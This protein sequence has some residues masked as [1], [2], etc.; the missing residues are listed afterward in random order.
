[1]VLRAYTMHSHVHQGYPTS[2]PC[3]I[4]VNE[5]FGS[6]IEI[7]TQNKETNKEVYNVS[8]PSPALHQNNVVYSQN[9]DL[10]CDTLFVCVLGGE[11]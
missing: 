8:N 3:D 7:S 10:G 2:S 5:I 1:M 4:S 9:F 6:W 11:S